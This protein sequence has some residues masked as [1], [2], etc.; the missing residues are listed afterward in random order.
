MLTVSLLRHAKS[1]W[2]EPE[3][4]DFD[5]P[6]A[7]R[8][9]KTAPRMGAFLADQHVSPELILCSSARRAR[10]TLDLVLP[11]LG[12]GPEAVFEDELYHAGAPALLKRL[13]KVADDIHHVMLVGHNPALHGLALDLAATGDK[14]DLRALA[15]KLPTAAIVVLTFNV[16]R[17]RQVRRGG[18]HLTLFMTPKRLP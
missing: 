8:G 16:T 15:S 14:H 10:A 4:A 11:H 12:A 2:A 1:S 6:L 18:G 9:E 3:K 7:A 17:W 13:R 5:R